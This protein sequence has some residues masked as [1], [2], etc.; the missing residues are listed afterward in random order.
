MMKRYLPIIVF[1]GLFLLGMAIFFF[2]N[3]SSSPWEIWGALDSASAVA[4]AVMAIVGYWEYIRSEDKIKIVFDIEGE[5]VDT[6]L[7]ILRR[8]LTRSELFGLL[9]MIEKTQQQF[10]IKTFN[11]NPNFID[12]IHKVVRGRSKELVIPMTKEEA[13]Q[14]NIKGY[15]D[16]NENR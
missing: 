1:A 5:K 13:S 12:E 9:R 2:S 4:L 14:F 16:G 3:K 11:D 8:N 10:H 15:T 6:G 7:S